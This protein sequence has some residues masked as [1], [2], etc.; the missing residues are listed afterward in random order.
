MTN[1]YVY[2]LRR[3]DKVDPFNKSKTCPFYIGKGRNGR[4]REHRQEATRLLKELGRKPYRVRVIHKLWESELDFIEEIFIKELTEEQSFEIECFLINKYGRVN[5]K[6]G[7][8]A[9][10]TEGGDGVSGFVHSEGSRKRMS[11]SHKGKALSEEHRKKTSKT[12]MG[13]SVSEKTRTIIGDLY[14]GKN[15]SV[16]H[17]KKL[18][19]AHKGK[20]ISEEHRKNLSIAFKGRKNPNFGKKPSEDAINKNREAHLGKR[21]SEETRQKMSD[22]LKR[23][24]AQKRGTNA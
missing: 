8:L 6:T 1:F 15:L 13:H 16:E 3:P 17:R 7:I 12:L 22:S 18:S 2:I 5:N 9:N 24:H 23:Y 21:A 19:I 11:E 10:L 4:V 14:R 20:I